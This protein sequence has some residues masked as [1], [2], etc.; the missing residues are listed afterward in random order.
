MI[1]TSCVTAHFAPYTNAAYID[2]FSCAD[3]D[4]TEVCEF[5]KEAFLAKSY[6]RANVLIRY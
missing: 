2:V 3:Y 5:V 1:E 4:E 6:H